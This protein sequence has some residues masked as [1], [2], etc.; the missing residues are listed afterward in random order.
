[1]STELKTHPQLFHHTLTRYATN[2]GP[3]IQ[4]TGPNCDTTSSGTPGYIGLTREEAAAL[5]SDLY[6]FARGDEVPEEGEG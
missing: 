3:C 5:A 1:M 2:Y 6:M 4:V